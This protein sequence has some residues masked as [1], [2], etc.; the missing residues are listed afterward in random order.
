ML[1]YRS[2]LLGQMPSISHGKEEYTWYIRSE[3]APLIPGIFSRLGF[4]LIIP[5]PTRTRASLPTIRECIRVFDLCPVSHV[6]RAF[7]GAVDVDVI[8]LQQ[9]IVWIS[10]GEERVGFE[11][12]KAEDADLMYQAICI[13]VDRCHA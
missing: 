13:L 8:D 7:F 5:L 11:T 12:S 6:F 9:R 3:V 10:A 2:G 4:N 1:D